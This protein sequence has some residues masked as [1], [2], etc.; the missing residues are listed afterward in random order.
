M[1]VDRLLRLAIRERRIITF[2]LR[3][4]HRRAEPHDYGI[5]GGVVKLFQWTTLFATVSGRPTSVG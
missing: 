5:M 3:R 4:L 1:D 2:R